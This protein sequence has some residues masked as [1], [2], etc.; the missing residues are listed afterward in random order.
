MLYAEFNL[1]L[2]S[3]GRHDDFFLWSLPNDLI[4]NSKLNVHFCHSLKT[5]YFYS[6]PAVTLE[7][8]YEK[9]I[10]FLVSGD[11]QRFFSTFEVQKGHHESSNCAYI[12]LSILFFISFLYFCFYCLTQLIFDFYCSAHFFSIYF[13][14][15]QDNYFT[16]LQWVLSYI[17][18][19]QPWSYMY[20]P[21][22]SRLPPPSLP[23]PSGSSQC[24]R[25]ERLSH[26]PN[27]GW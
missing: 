27:L 2:C 15:L 18:M 16:I 6:Q 10:C 11:I 21:S 9:V 8:H 23:D 5:L 12:V 13:Y 19:N 4:L 25:P 26:A 24:T 1:Y 20:S 22:Q 3:F 17:D 7:S 14:Q